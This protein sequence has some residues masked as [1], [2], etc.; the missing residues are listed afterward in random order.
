MWD[1]CDPQSA[2]E[3]EV[4]PIWDL[5]AQSASDYEVSQNRQLVATGEGDFYALLGIFASATAQKKAH[6]Q[7]LL[8]GSPLHTQTTEIKSVR[9]PPAREVLSQF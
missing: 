6:T 3:G 4:E 8:Y 9:I 1:E 2:E 7:R 5:A